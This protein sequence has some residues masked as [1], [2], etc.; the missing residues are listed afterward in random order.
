MHSLSVSPYVHIFQLVSNSKS[1][2]KQVSCY[3]AI[4]LIPNAQ[5]LYIRIRCVYHM[6]FPPYFV[7]AVV[8]CIELSGLKMLFFYGSNRHGID[9]ISHEKKNLHKIHLF[10]SLAK[11]CEIL[12]HICVYFGW[13]NA[14]TINVNFTTKGS[15]NL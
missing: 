2:S 9:K 15:D 1:R 3:L 10:H 7:A 5:W 12:Y 8:E 14:F 11:I 6:F 13:F 4:H